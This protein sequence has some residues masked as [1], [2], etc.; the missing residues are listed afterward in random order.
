MNPT[1]IPTHSVT[2]TE[3]IRPICAKK[4]KK[5]KKSVFESV[6]ITSNASYK[7]GET[8]PKKKQQ[9][10]F[11]NVPQQSTTNLELLTDNKKLATVFESE[12]KPSHAEIKAGVPVEKK[13]EM[14]TFENNPQSPSVVIQRQDTTSVFENEPKESHSSA[15]GSLPHECNY[16]SAVGGM[17]VCVSCFSEKMI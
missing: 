5:T 17:C 12:P 11:E 8:C 3:D 6:P 2:S 7:T 16:V 4:K 10:I 9:C 15:K 1:E 14:S 13:E